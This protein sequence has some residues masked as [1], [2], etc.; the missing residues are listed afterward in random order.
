MTDVATVGRHETIRVYPSAILLCAMAAFFGIAAGY[1]WLGEARD[2]LNYL[3]VWNQLTSHYDPTF[4][5]FERGYTWSSWFARFYLM[6]DFQ[7]FYALLAT[8]ALAVKFRLIW[9]H[10]DAPLVA[11][12]AYLMILYPLHEYT[13]IRASVGLG[14]AYLAID[15]YLERRLRRAIVCA[16]VAVLFHSS[17]LA[18]GLA[19]VAILLLRR[20]PPVVT[21]TALGATATLGAA[22]VPRILD[23]LQQLNPLVASYLE[24]SD[25]GGTPN[26]LSGETILLVLTI[27]A[28]AV[29]LR[30]WRRSGDMF[31]FFLG[32]W[33]VVLL[34]A[35]AQMPV[36]AFRLE[37][38]FIFPFFLF[39]F[40]YDQS[41]GSRMPSLLMI[42]TGAWMLNIALASGLISS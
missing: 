30:P 14:F 13:Q 41:V 31:F 17:T 42:A 2:R 22:V 19:V 5:R 38:A 29:F 34:A 40:R 16:V 37:E 10:A 20:M 15:S 21:A 28:S 12:L 9:K 36:F 8:V 24:Q 33:S 18:I 4:S 26:L 23:L 27:M 39:A 35:F 32:S 1:G 11:A 3:D 6:L 25:A 7:Q